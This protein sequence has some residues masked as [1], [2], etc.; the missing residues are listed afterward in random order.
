MQ[1]YEVH[2]NYGGALFTNENDAISALWLLG[3]YH[4]IEIK[5]EKVKNDL[6]KDDYFEAFPLAITKGY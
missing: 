6:E 4:D 3:A 5:R 2:S 1:K